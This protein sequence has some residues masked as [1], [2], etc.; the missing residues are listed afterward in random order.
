MKDYAENNGGAA[1][2]GGWDHDALKTG[3]AD[4]TGTIDIGW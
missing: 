1:L 2:A 3:E 4:R